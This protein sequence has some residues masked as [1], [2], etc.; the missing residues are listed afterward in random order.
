MIPDSLDFILRPTN[1]E[2]A[3]AHQLPAAPS[4]AAGRISEEAV[5][6]GSQAASSGPDDAEVWVDVPDDSTPYR[7]AYEWPRKT[8]KVV[9]N[10][11]RPLPEH[12]YRTPASPTVPLGE[13]GPHSSDDLDELLQKVAVIHPRIAKQVAA[14]PSGCWEWQ[15]Y[16]NSIG[17]PMINIDRV[18]R[19]VYRIV[20]E[21]ATGVAPGDLHVCHHCDNPICTR[22]S[23]L[24]LGTDL[25]NNRDM[26]AKGRA[27]PPPT[28]W[29][30]KHPLVHAS[31]SAVRMAREAF[32]GGESAESIARRMDHAAATVRGWIRGKT[33]L[34]AGGPTLG[35]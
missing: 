24:F 14:V 26:W 28:H 25:D 33:R 3:A 4:P 15:G 8:V 1:D 16:T 17:R 13:A 6:K 29:G 27:V 35:T 30:E 22:P 32:A 9:D 31:D 34:A 18:P 2:Q 20:Y 19:L 11:P 21:I 23:H 7:D 12:N 10:R 5:R